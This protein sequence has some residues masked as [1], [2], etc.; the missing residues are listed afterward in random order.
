MQPVYEVTECD[1]ILSA[2]PIFFS[3]TSLN[4]ALSCAQAYM[5]MAGVTAMVWDGIRL[6]AGFYTEDYFS[7]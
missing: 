5:E 3:T 6:Y 1:H 4:C 2:R 7:S